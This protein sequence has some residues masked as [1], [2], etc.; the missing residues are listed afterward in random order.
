MD[1][2]NLA[3]SVAEE[4]GK[5]F[6]HPNKKR[7]SQKI[8]F[9]SDVGAVYLG[10]APK[11]N[12]Q[13][14]ACVV[15]DTAKKK[16]DKEKY[17]VF[18]TTD[19]NKTAKQIVQTYELRWEIEE[20]FRQLKD[21]WNLEDF[22]STKL[23]TIVFHIV[24]TLL[25]YLFFQLYTLF[26][27]GEHLAGKSLPVIMKN[28]KTE[29]HPFYIIYSGNMFGI[30]GLDELLDLYADCDMKVRGMIKAVIPK[31]KDGGSG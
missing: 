3:T 23:T 9:V 30:L 8:A 31:R 4:E 18:I 28:Y 16:D 14:N 15:W 10:T 2:Y 29:L 20:D 25:G 1:I 6:V 7:K 27:E 17:H 11:H 19:T 12:V 22:K 5:W 24:C 13:L 26:D 21:F